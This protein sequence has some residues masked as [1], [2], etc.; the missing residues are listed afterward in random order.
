MRLLFKAEDRGTGEDWAEVV[1]CH[2]CE[3]L[4]LPHVEYELAAEYEGEAYRRPGVV[5]ANMAPRPVTLVL[6]NE[7]LL[8]HDPDYPAEERFKVR[9][10]TVEVVVEV[11]GS[12][13]PPGAAWMGA[14]PEG[15]G[16]AL[17]VFA[18]YVMLDAWIANQDRHHETWG[19]L[20][21]GEP[22]TLAPTFDHGAALARNLTDKERE[23]RLT[24]RDRN[25]TVEAFAKAGRSAFYAEAVD[26]RPLGT[27]DAFHAFGAAVPEA[28]NRWLGRLGGVNRE[29]VYGILKRV[30]S[31]RMSPT[32]R[33]FTLELL[34]TN[35]RRLLE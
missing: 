33:D 35:Q 19:A 9:Q 34:L 16:T 18:G 11:L 13:G 20:G 30:P 28:K 21:D 6:G 24:T 12:L 2:L 17:D 10:H 29:A 31:E 5:C 15:I 1:S 26:S 8:A 27:L 3:L 4:G 14:T 22:M 32:C 23:E 7:L 25:R